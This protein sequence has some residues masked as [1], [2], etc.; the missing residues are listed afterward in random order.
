VRLVEPRRLSAAGA[1]DAEEG[2]VAQPG[3]RQR[4]R[5]LRDHKKRESTEIAGAGR[6]AGPA[7][8]TPRC[9]KR[10]EALGRRVGPR[11]RSAQ[12]WLLRLGLLPSHASELLATAPCAIFRLVLARGMW[13]RLALGHRRSPLAGLPG[14]GACIG[15]LWLRHGRLPVAR[16]ATTAVQRQLAPPGADAGAAH[17]ALIESWCKREFDREGKQLA[18]AAG[19]GRR[20]AQAA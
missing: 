5:P 4:P 20:G 1:R 19:L 14:G 7:R 12:G 6:G 9:P 17:G 8:P 16:A 15:R 11:Q 18:A 10:L 13:P 2:F 3:Q